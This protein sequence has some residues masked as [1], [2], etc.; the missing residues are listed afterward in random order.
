MNRRTAIIKLGFL[1]GG[2]VLLP[3]CN[4]SKESSG[5]ALENLQITAKQEKV[6][7]S[8]VSTLIPEGDIP[9]AESL[10]V[11][12]FVWIMVDDTLTKRRQEKF[13]K[14]LDL[15]NNE[16]QKTE[17]RSFDQIPE[18]KRFEVLNEQSENTEVIGINNFIVTTK[19][20]TIRG[21]LQSEYIMTKVMPYKLVPGIYGNCENINPKERINIY[22]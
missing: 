14:G 22:A 1:T 8:V 15:F 20:L 12:N 4:F 19:Y 7:R 16:V 10:G 5:I 9:G 21:Y 3:S 17:G 11:H 2:L 13:I 18:I 6:L